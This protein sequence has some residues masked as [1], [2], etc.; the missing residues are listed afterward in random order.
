MTTTRLL[1]T[2]LPHSLAADADVHV[3]VFVT[4]RLTPT[5]TPATVADFPD[6]A[7]W[8]ATLAAGTL[9]LVT[10]TAPDGIA[11]Q[12][13]GP[14]P[15]PKD[16][17]AVFP[18]DT[19][20]VGFPSPDVTDE[21]WVTYP[22]SPVD[23]HAL[24]LHLA[25]TLVSPLV[26]PPVGG[27]PVAESVL[28]R[29]VER[30]P[31]LRDLLALRDQRAERDA[32]ILR[33]RLDEAL[34]SLGQRTG[35][36]GGHPSEPLGSTSAV[37]TLLRDRDGERRLTAFLDSL[38]DAGDLDDP[39][40]G[41]MRDVH[42]ARRFY[43]R[44]HRPY[45]DRPDP[46]AP[47]PP[48]P[49]VPEH[50]FHERA[51]SLGSTPALTR[52]LGL[53]VD[54]LVKDR[55]DRR[56]LARARWVSARFTPADGADVVRIAPPR[57]W[58]ESSGE[59]WRAV[60]SGAWSGGA[61][62]LGDPDRY[63]V[64]DL[65]PDASALKLE[66]HVRDLPRM[67]A[68]E[69][70]GDPAT[71][72]PASLRATGF[73][74][75]K[76]DRDTALRAQVERAQGFADTDDDG[77]TTGPDLAYDD[78]VRGIRLEVWD[79]ETRAWHS[80]HERRVDVTA[81]DRK[82]LT[83]VADRGF[84]QLTGLTGVPEE[85][86]PYHL[87]EVFAGWDGWS[88]SAPRPGK[89]I[90]HGDGTHGPAGEELVLDEPPD[91]PATHVH[92]HSRVEPGTLPWLRYGRRY[93]FRVR[94]VDLAGNAVPRPPADGPTAGAVDAARDQ[95][96]RLRQVYD[97]R[98]RSGLLGQV[99]DDILGRLPGTDGA[100]G[101]EGLL[102]DAL[103][104]AGDGLSAFQDRMTT[105]G[106]LPSA[107]RDVP[108]E[109]VTG[110][111]DIDALVRER[112][113]D[114]ADAAGT[115]AG[116]S[117][118]R[119]VAV[120]LG[121]LARSE[122]TWRRRPQLE[123][124]AAALAGLDDTRDPIT[125]RPDG[126]DPLGPGLPDLEPVPPDVPVV[127]TPRPFLRWHPVPPPTLVARRALGVGESLQRLVVRDDTAAER[128]L[129]P[130]K[131]TQLEAEQHGRFD[132]VMGA[133]DP[134]V[135]DTLLAAALKERGTLLDERIQ[136]LDDPNGRL[137][138]DGIALVTRPG[139]D[140]D[141]VV[142]LADID[143]NRDTAL[144]E[145]QYVVHDTDQLVLPY[146]PDPLA[147]GVSLVFY[148]SGPPHALREPRVLQ[149]V[150]LPFAGEWP[151]V[152]P[153][154]LVVEPGTELGARRDG[155]RVIVALPPG[156]Q[157]RV[158][159]SSALD[160]DELTVLGLWRTHLAS[161]T[162]GGGA[163]A[164]ARA[165]LAQA[166]ANG[167]FWWLTPSHDVRLVHAVRRP[168][169]PPEI[170]A[171]RVFLRPPGL[172]V[173]ALVGVVDVHGPSTERLVLEAS[174]T[175]WVDDLAADAPARVERHD[176]VVSA[177]VEP[178]ERFGLL[179][180]VDA[181][182]GGDTDT[183][184]VVSHRAVQTFADTH[185]R[186]VAYIPR[187][188]TRYAEFFDPAELPAPDDPASAGAPVALTVPSSA[189][190]AAP[191]VTDVAPLLLWE[192]G[193]EPDQ[194][195][196]FRRTRR[197]GARIW[198]R[199]PWFSSG[200]GELL[201]V[202]LSPDGSVPSSLSSRWAKDPVLVTGVPAQTTVPPLVRPADLVLTT[203][204]GEVVDQRPGRPVTPVVATSLVDAAGSP[205]VQ[206]LGYRPEFHP[207][208]KEWYVDVAMDP[209]A[210]LW[211]F[212]RL[213]LA[214]Y[215]PDSIDGADLSPVVLADWVQPLPERVATINRRTDATVRV[216]VTGPMGATRLRKREPDG[217]TN[218]A[219]DAA[220]AVL[221]ASR[222]LFATVQE[223]PGHAGGDLDWVD[224][225]RGRLPLV[226]YEGF[227]ATWSA[228]LDLPEP[229]PVAT[230][231]SSTRLRVLVEE[232]EYFDADPEAGPKEGK[233]STTQRV[234]YAD[235]LAL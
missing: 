233:P 59:H 227:T 2:A 29:M 159:L 89:I 115:D 96:G 211:P 57:T 191:E 94:G 114:A 136:D 219:L 144:G 149:T 3:S 16:W 71:A 220:D 61:L 225:A 87:H 81:G 21:A 201:A 172:T 147:R 92:I 22:A 12:R 190:P 31:G 7:D 74:I 11:A 134:A 110:V 133:S 85:D 141:A 138:Q 84:L 23:D 26:P 64:I 15:D 53:V 58:C 162:G 126:L 153:L 102:L 151:A 205:P 101:T 62:P 160:E 165:L 34:A 49:E 194:P 145:G 158:A 120:A 189:R 217:Q 119:G 98:T 169:R 116:A 67:L 79:D 55:A 125:R 108:R 129:V 166:A 5:S 139:A 173:V 95:L 32:R 73:S 66:Q 78:V 170:A 54:L 40:L 104:A 82:V 45:V 121:R 52:A 210:S 127:T 163:G 105:E 43:Q 33:R 36:E 228:E 161:G 216:T 111:V 4:H 76:V 152:E 65:D 72:A 37:E 171:L 103:A 35:R 175:E 196:A 88:L 44:G 235:H 70:N 157:V 209:G 174:W 113:A 181:V 199:R 9:D 230:P 185:H 192:E 221:R 18:R 180:L 200:D 226:G 222:E 17:S 112:V 130:P 107:A 135:P 164:A 39:I 77:T 48:R 150:V 90:V 143:A 97:A 6:T 118:R 30:H 193:T 215:Q 168:V 203:V 47:V 234:V 117:V 93:S 137:H 60:A 208:R 213:A 75:A 156:E 69:L 184:P 25:S 106:H 229:L 155:N 41:A 124:D 27:N 28:G 179:H 188:R 183:A 20:V 83:D 202:V 198:L 231:G 13:V 24:D 132:A 100:D 42:A 142:T 109:A 56:L 46:D 178:D 232:V 38:L 177:P 187:G 14:A 10:D 128:H 197:S 146:L 148:D 91:D 131:C 218:D 204:A 154:R 224:H 223:A 68:S 80:L 63:T 167:W 140:P 186:R 182:L 195:F 99:R 212:V 86:G 207:G 19:P 176:V 1:A 123:V 51:A 206:V 214:R 50:D 8:P 122:Q